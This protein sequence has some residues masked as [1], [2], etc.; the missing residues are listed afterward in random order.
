MKNLINHEKAFI[1]LFNQTARYHHRHQV[2][3]D[4]IS[5]SVIALQN[6]LSFCE[7]REQKYLH[8]VARY[9]KKDVVRMAELLAHVVNGLD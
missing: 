2:F 7:K 1:S 4:F 3:E 6:A 5:C 8:I 9:E